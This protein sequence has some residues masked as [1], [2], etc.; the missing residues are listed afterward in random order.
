MPSAGRF[1]AS[2]TTSGRSFSVPLVEHET[3]WDYADEAFAHG[4]PETFRIDASKHP[5]FGPP[6][7]PLT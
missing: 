4:I 3:R 7:W 1:T 5:L 6:R 2:T